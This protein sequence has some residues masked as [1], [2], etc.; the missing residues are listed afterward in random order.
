M[1]QEERPIDCTERTRMIIVVEDDVNIGE[2]LV[3]AIIQETPY[4]VIHFVD[5]VS[6]L[7]TVETLK[8]DLFILD[9]HLP[10]MTGI[11][12][13]DKLQTIEE[14]AHIPTL[15]ISAR[16]PWP[17]LKKRQ[18]TGLNKPLDL[19]EFLETIEILLHHK[20]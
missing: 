10:R 13:Y 4:Q 14:I 9:Y 5:G 3:Q 1:A 16:L 6:V 8:P 19:D 17:E 15:M 12:L 2:V 20:S 18:I 7:N 11:E